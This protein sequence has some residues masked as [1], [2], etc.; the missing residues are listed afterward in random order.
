[1]LRRIESDLGWATE[2]RVK[3]LLNEWKW[4]ESDDTLPGP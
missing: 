4:D 1:L 3:Q 2:Y